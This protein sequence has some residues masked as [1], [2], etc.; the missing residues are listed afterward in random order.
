MNER[1]RRRNCNEFSNW[2]QVGL[3]VKNYEKTISQ[4]HECF[5]FEHAVL[6]CH[7]TYFH[8]SMFQLKHVT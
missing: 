5:Q 7:D 4:N 1:L 8:M 6:K 2:F 3:S